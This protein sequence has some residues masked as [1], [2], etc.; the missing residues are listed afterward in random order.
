MRTVAEI[1]RTPYFVWACVA[2]AGGCLA[3]ATAVCARKFLLGLLEQFVRLPP[4]SKA[5]LVTAV[6]VATVFAQKPANVATNLHESARIEEVMPAASAEGSAT[7]NAEDEEMRRHGEASTDFTDSHGSGEGSSTNQH[8]ATQIQIRDNPCQSV[9]KTSTDSKETPCLPSSYNSA[10]GDSNPTLSSNDVVRGYRLEAV[11]TNKAVSY[12]RPTNAR[13]VSTWHLTDAYRGRVWVMLGEEGKGKKGKGR[14]AE[15]NSSVAESEAVGQHRKADRS[16]LLPSSIFL[17]PLGRHVVTSLWAHT[18]GKVR[19]QLRNASNE[20]AVIGAPMFARHGQSYLWTAATTNGSVVLTWENFFLGN[21]YERAEVS[22]SS[23]QTTERDETPPVTRNGLEKGA[24][25]DSSTPVLP[26]SGNMLGENGLENPEGH[27]SLIL[28]VSTNVASVS[29]VVKRQVVDHPAV[30]AQLELFPNGDFIARSN[31]I[32][33]V[34]RRVNPDDWDDDGIPND[35]DGA[36]LVAADE[37][38]F[39]PRQDLSSIAHSNNYYWVDLVAP[40]ANALVTFTG[41]GASNLPDP[42][43]VAKAGE[44]NRVVLLLGKSY[45]AD[46]RLTLVCVGA[47]HPDIEIGVDADGHLT[48][49]R[50]VRCE[51]VDGSPVAAFRASAVAPR[52]ASGGRRVRFTPAPDGADVSWNGNYCCLEPPP[53]PFT[54]PLFSCDGNCGCGGCAVG[55]YTCRFEGFELSFADWPCGCSHES[56]PD[57]PTYPDEDEPDHEPQGLSVSATFSESAIIFEDEY[58]NA[59]GE[60]V[61]RRSTETEAEFSVYG[62][63][64]GG[65]YSFELRDGGRLER[66]GGSFLP[67]E[68]TVE[69][70][71]SFKIKVRYRAQSASGGAGDVKAVATF[72]EEESGEKITSEATL[73]AVK[74]TIRP[75]Q[76]EGGNGSEGRHK[77]GVYE[78]IDCGF[79]PEV[80]NVSWNVKGGGRMQKDKTYRC[81]LDAE[82]NPLEVVCGGVSYTPSILVVEP[83]GVRALNPGVVTYGLSSLSAGGI[84]LQ[85]DIQVLPLD[86]S[87]QEIWVEEVPSTMGVQTG[88]FTHSYFDGDRCHSRENGAGVW[89]RVLD[90]NIIDARDTAA[91]TQPYPRMTPGGQL[92]ESLSVGWIAGENVWCIPLG[93]NVPQTT[94]GAEPWK[95]FAADETQTFTIDEFGTAGVRKLRHEAVR[96]VLGSVYLDGVKLW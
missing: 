53:P 3:A 66:V 77:F 64:K 51:I 37:P 94:D 25:R 24:L 74:V 11:R 1:F 4:S 7:L 76:I 38:Q 55:T 13:L 91:C 70:G 22:V 54:V 96:E 67:R 62:G 73:T 60:T 69:A 81:P 72:T 49:C 8:E 61:A 32:E 29:S 6:V 59:P 85:L 10:L 87:F 39:G 23:S 33:R 5:D 82:S 21:P 35:V 56:P 28:S 12:T 36:P 63:T 93:W 92:S 20:I 14:S 18:W 31:D 75:I 79:E 47:S 78:L 41:S 15:D 52:A 2:L 30:N 26:T 17:F 90:E 88:Y 46:C 16:A 57:R 34:Y 65:S 83:S 27:S 95:C 68:G 86:V 80:A 40:A 19:P 9:D 84:G 42:S 43:F 71:E 45:T 48:V 89:F 50:P 44:T 58:E